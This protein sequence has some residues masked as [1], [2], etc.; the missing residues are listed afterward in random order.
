MLI[1]KKGFIFTNRIK[2]GLVILQWASNRKDKGPAAIAKL[3]RMF[4]KN[5]TYGTFAFYSLSKAIQT[6][7]C[8]SD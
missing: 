5:V 3:G 4:S 7:C 2:C 1:A 8:V 6:S